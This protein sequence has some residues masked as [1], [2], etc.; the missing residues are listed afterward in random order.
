[1]SLLTNGIIRENALLVLMIG[2]CPALACSGTIRDG[3]G[4]GMAA[5][6]VLVCSNIVVAMVRKIIPEQIRIPIFIIIISTFVT[7]TDY[8]MQAYLPALSAVLGIFVPLIVVN[9]MILGRAEAFAYK[10]GIF[11]SILD[12]IGMGAGF[13]L[14]LSVM[15]AIRELLGNGTLFKG[16]TIAGKSLEISVFGSNFEP[17]IFMILP[18]GAFLTIAFLIAIVNKIK[19]KGEEQA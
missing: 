4:M 2:L 9:C 10:N 6:F 12:G 5:T 14:C 11:D 18:P 7:I 3:F 16:I 19:A 17:M 15:G 8:T 1:M 13:T